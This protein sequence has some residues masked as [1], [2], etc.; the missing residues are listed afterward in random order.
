MEVAAP[1][2]S[3][4]MPPNQTLYVPTLRYV[5]EHFFVFLLSRLHCS[6]VSNLSEKL[7]REELKKLLYSLFSAHGAII[8][9]VALKTNK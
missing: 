8:E 5:R 2:A 4:E 9:V 6:Y 3:E 7:P 1:N